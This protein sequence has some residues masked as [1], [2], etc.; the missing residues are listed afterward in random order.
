MTFNKQIIHGKPFDEEIGKSGVEIIQTERTIPPEEIPI[1]PQIERRLV[2]KLDL[3]LMIWAFLAYFANLLD[4]NNMRKYM[5]MVIIE[6][7]C[8]YV[9]LLYRKC[10]HQRHGRGLEPEFRCI[11]LGSDHVFYWLHCVSA[12]SLYRK[13][14]F[15]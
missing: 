4:R 15:E 3:R 6:Y 8:S 9:Y 1:D 2:R 5:H 11:Q 14:G 7:S 13:R 10:I 12:I